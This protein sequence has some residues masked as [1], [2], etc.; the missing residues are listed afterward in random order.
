MKIKIKNKEGTF[1]VTAI[2]SETVKT[3][4]LSSEIKAVVYVKDD[5]RMPHKF[6]MEE[7][8]RYED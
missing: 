1:K 7:I 2:V 6:L 3:G 4:P 8:E 5:K